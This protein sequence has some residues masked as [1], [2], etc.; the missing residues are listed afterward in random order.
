MN[1]PHAHRFTERTETPFGDV[2]YRVERCQG[3]GAWRTNFTAVRPPEVA[4]PAPVIT[5]RGKRKR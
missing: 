4:R 5:K 3:C 2:P 1:T